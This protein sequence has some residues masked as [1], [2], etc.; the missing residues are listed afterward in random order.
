MNAKNLA[1]RIIAR[2][3]RL[4]KIFSSI[5]P[6]SISIPFTE[7]FSICIDP[8]DIRG[9]SFHIVREFFR[10]EIALNGYEPRE[11]KFIHQAIM[12]RDGR[13]VF[14]DIGANI[15]LYSLPVA[16][17]FPETNIFAFE[18]HPINSLCLKRSILEN[19]IKNLFLEE[20]GLSDKEGVAHLFLD[21]SDSGGHSLV[22]SNMWNNKAAT[23]K[24]DI[25][26]HRLDDWFK[27]KNLKALD[28]LKIDVQGAEPAVFDGGMQTLKKFQ[29]D[30]L[31]EI[32]FSA[33]LERGEVMS[34]LKSICSDYYFRNMEDDVWRPL[35]GLSVDIQRRQDEGYLISDYFFSKGNQ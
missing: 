21:E 27:E 2:D 10:P 31:I 25:T 8:R 20:I 24:I 22:S 14:F 6:E 26:L 28:V 18:P 15:G 12:R 32:Q 34:H 17:N 23:K 35:S 3:K 16:L 33:L 30:I 9:P 4:K 19:K 11:R 29:P 1:W 13:A 7:G 5:L